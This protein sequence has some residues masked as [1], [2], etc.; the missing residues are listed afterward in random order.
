[1]T[2]IYTTVGKNSLEKKWSSPPSQ[3]ES[4]MQCLGAAPKMTEW[5]QYISKANHAT[6]QWSKFMS[7]P[8]MPRKLKLTDSM[9]TYN[10]F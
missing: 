1:M 9:K 2:I 4:E 7:Q 6:S 10:T 3:Q 5:S 8:L